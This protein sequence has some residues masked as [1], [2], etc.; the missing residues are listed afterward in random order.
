[1]SA[2]GPRRAPGSIGGSAAPMQE[3]VRVGLI[4]SGFIS[5]IHAE[6]LRRVAGAEIIAV[7]S[8]GPGRAERFADERGIPRHFTDYR[9]LL[10]IPEVDLVV[11]G[12]P[13]DLHCQATC[14]A[15]AGKHVVVEK[16]MAPSL[17]EYDRTIA[18]FERSGVLLGY[19]E[20]L[21]FTPT[22][23][24]LEGAGR[25]G[26]PG[27][28]PPGQAIREPRPAAGLRRRRS[29]GRADPG[30]GHRAVRRR[31]TEHGRAARELADGAGQYR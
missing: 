19:A 5:S 31:D 21:C 18:A 3:T 2:R 28:G 24:R 27:P 8:P 26:G 20:E 22:Y 1:L 30:D 15:A 29:R 12:L 16:P 10:D 11:L 25:R 17:A 7:A 14:L 4:G 13:N 6:A 9:A 23:V